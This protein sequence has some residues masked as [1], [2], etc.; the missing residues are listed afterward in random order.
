MTRLAK[1]LKELLTD[2]ISITYEDGL[3]TLNTLD[4]ELMERD[5][6]AEDITYLPSRPDSSVDPCP[7]NCE[8]CKT[9]D[10]Q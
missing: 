1:T 9:H 8:Y 4:M 3:A 5:L 2:G 10:A 6:H 7:H